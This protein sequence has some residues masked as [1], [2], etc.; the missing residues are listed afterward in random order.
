MVLS[1]LIMGAVVG[2]DGALL[3]GPLSFLIGLILIVFLGDSNCAIQFVV[4]RR[5]ISAMY[6]MLAFILI[7][8]M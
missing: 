5:S 3:V 1:Y 4:A 2:A 8:R 6:T 7:D